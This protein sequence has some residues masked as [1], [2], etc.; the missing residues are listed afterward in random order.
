MTRRHRTTLL[1]S[2]ALGQ[3]WVLVTMCRLERLMICSEAPTF[4]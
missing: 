3:V 4:S 2:L 1:E